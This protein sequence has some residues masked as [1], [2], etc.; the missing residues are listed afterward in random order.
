MSSRA[1]FNAES[2]AGNT[3][4]PPASVASAKQRVCSSGGPSFN[5][6]SSIPLPSN[7]PDAMTSALRGSG[8]SSC[9]CSQPSW[10]LDSVGWVSSVLIKYGL[11]GLFFVRVVARLG[12]RLGILDGLGNLGLNAWLCPEPFCSADHELLAFMRAMQDAHSTI[13][14]PLRDHAVPDEHIGSLNVSDEDEITC[15]VT[16]N[17]GGFGWMRF[18]CSWCGSGLEKFRPGLEGDD[19]RQRCQ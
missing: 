17:S 19:C 7:A 11:H 5:H 16:L 6:C 9:P 18:G 15:A 14:Q 10:D 12:S 13:S 8:V 4:K 1:F 3:S 2:A